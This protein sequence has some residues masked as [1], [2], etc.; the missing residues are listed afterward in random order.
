MPTPAV[1]FGMTWVLSHSSISTAC[2]HRAETLLV[3]T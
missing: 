1:H 2:Q 3:R